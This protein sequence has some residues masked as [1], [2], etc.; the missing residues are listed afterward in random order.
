MNMLRAMY[1]AVMFLGRTNTSSV[2]TVVS[3]ERT[4][5]Y[6]EKAG[7]MHSPLPY[8]FAQVHDSL[9]KLHK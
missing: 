5:F 7:G 8:V 9:G 4:V 3:V 2:Q 6:R 1:A